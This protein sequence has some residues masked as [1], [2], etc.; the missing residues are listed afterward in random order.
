MQKAI[1]GETKGRRR[2]RRGGGEE[3]I[4]SEQSS[5]Y[6]ISPA[7]KVW[8]IFLQKRDITASPL[9]V[10]TS[11]SHV[12]PATARSLASSSGIPCNL[13]HALSWILSCIQAKCL[14]GGIQNVGPPE[15]NRSR[16]RCNIKPNMARDNLKALQGTKAKSALERVES[17]Q[18]RLS[19]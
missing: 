7:A 2:R 11:Q 15:K 6:Y 4:W 13:V 9:E 5:A 16:W 12:A 10:L 14:P 18:S 1:R 3:I 19:S 17:Q 8:P